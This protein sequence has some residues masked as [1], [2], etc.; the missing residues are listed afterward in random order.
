MNKSGWGE[1][2]MGRT[3]LGK[4][5]V[6]AR[7]LA[8]LAAVSRAAMLAA[9]GTAGLLAACEKEAPPKTPPA[10]D[11]RVQLLFSP[12]MARGPYTADLADLTAHLVEALVVS[13]HDV[14]RRAKMELAA[15]GAR[16]VTALRRFV[17]RYR[18]DPGGADYLRNAAD[19]LSLSEDP[20]AQPILCGLLEHPSESLRIQ[21]LRGLLVH[22][23]PESYEPVLKLLANSP[24]GYQAEIC[25]ALAKLDLERAQ[26][27]WLLWVEQGDNPSVW[28]A[29]LPTLALIRDPELV[30]RVRAV[31][32]RTDLDTLTRLWLS[33]VACQAG[34]LPKDEAALATLRAA[35]ESKNPTERD[36]AVR[37]LASAGRYDELAWTLEHDEA[38]GLRELVARA[39][40][41]QPDHADARFLLE[42]AA[43]DPEESVRT[44]ALTALALHGRGEAVDEAL[45]WL[46][47]P[48]LQE[49]QGGLQILREAMASRPEV[50]RRAWDVLRP[51]LDTLATR[52]P[53]E[54]AMLL[55]VLGQ[56]PDP[57]ATRTLLELGRGAQG[58][59]EGT[60]AQRFILRQSVNAGPIAQDALYEL[61][62]ASEDGLLRLD[63]LE[64]FSALGGD[65]SRE[66]L[67]KVFDDPRT[68]STEMVYVADRLAR[69]GPASE[70]AW[71][72]KRAALAMQD[73]SA[74]EALQGILWRWYPPPSQRD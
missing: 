69:I 55:K 27:Q 32:Q 53:V 17:E 2:T 26:R 39:A 33:A 1:R 5:S 10:L 11:D 46:S 48:V 6:L 54:R 30:L 65:H 8:R 23:S 58:D 60:R 18:S 71:Q 45:Q 72:L 38:P 29:I 40:A 15:S 52:T 73:P 35:R 20:A 63:A 59:L 66:L 57:E 50:A 42:R 16:G 14:Q 41:R 37:A 36:L 21:V 22:P 70:V 47:S 19:V 44:P 13:E 9:V 49:V 64:A 61:W 67:L 62:R 68:S 28:P 43:N 74:R 24:P 4:D 12:D 3:L 7:G 51:R 56:I 31:L 34:D 25:A